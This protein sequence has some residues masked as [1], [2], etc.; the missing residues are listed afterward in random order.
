MIDLNMDLA[1]TGA[2]EVGASAWG[3]NPSEVVRFSD[4]DAIVIAT[5]NSSHDHLTQ[6]ALDFGLV[7]RLVPPGEAL[8]EA[9]ARSVQE[10]MDQ[11]ASLADRARRV[12]QAARLN[13]PGLPD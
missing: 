3:N 13:P 7:G 11:E 2:Q 8:A 10:L 5:P 1:Q 4:I 9:N 12:G 6:E